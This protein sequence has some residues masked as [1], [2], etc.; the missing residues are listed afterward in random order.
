MEPKKILVV[1]DELD[2]LES[3]SFALEKEGYTV[4]TATDGHQAYG[5]ARFEEP[6]LI[7]FDVMLPRKNGYEVARRLN[8]DARAGLDVK[9]CPMIILTARNPDSA[10]REEFLKTWSGASLHML[11]PF[12]LEVLL[13]ETAKLLQEA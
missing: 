4:I 9:P 6:D 12:D 13:T 2:V 7:I 1:E 8:E 10:E 11:K 5:A 3:L